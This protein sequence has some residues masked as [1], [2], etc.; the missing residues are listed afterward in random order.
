MYVKNRSVNNTC[1]ICAMCT[2]S[3]ISWISCKTNLELLTNI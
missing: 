3:W 1:D 2:G